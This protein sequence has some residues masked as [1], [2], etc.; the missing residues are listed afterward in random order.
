MTR[1]VCNLNIGQGGKDET[2]LELV[3]GQ[4]R[5]RGGWRLDVM[6]RLSPLL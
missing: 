4:C 1:E 6:H 3:Q 2:S 5:R